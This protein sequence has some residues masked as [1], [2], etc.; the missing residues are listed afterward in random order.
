[1]L[2]SQEVQNQSLVANGEE[3]DEVV[4]SI[5][6]L[7]IMS[8]QLSSVSGFCKSLQ[9]TRLHST[10][11]EKKV[12]YRAA[13]VG[14]PDHDTAARAVRAWCGVDGA[15]AMDAAQGAI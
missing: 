10:C 3:L 9:K 12:R 14:P 11:I 4:A 7:Q 13:P 6:P 1:M 15:G 8:L 2:A 5:L